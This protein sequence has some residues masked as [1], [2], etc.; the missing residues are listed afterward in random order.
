M[1]TNNI[2][3]EYFS[4]LTTSPKYVFMSEMFGLPSRTFAPWHIWE[5]DPKVRFIVILAA[6]NSIECLNWT[7]WSWTNTCLYLYWV[8]VLMLH[9]LETGDN[10][11]LYIFITSSFNNGTKLEF[12]KPFMSIC[13]ATLTRSLAGNLRIFFVIR[14]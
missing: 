8:I 12:Y 3:M 9:M 1:P 4:F 6:A 11:K 5:N 7:S 14:S 2:C 10:K 13:C